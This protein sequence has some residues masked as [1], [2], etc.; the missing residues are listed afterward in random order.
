M[1]DGGAGMVETPDGAGMGFVMRENDRF[2]I[3]RGGIS[4]SLFRSRERARKLEKGGRIVN[5]V[6]DRE[7]G[8]RQHLAQGGKVPMLRMQAT[9]MR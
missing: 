2:S 8:N 9:S 3:C 5:G 4:G 1:W 6:R 7:T